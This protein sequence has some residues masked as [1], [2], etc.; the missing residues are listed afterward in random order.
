MAA[1]FV[2][3]ILAFALAGICTLPFLL[4]YRSVQLAQ[5]L[6]RHLSEAAFYSAYPAAFLSGDPFLRFWHTIPP[7]TTEQ[8]LL[9]GLAGLTLSL[10][11]CFVAR[12]DRRFWFYVAGILLITPLTFG[13]ALEPRGIAVLWHPYSLLAALPG[14]N[15]LR[16]PA[17]FFMLSVFCLS[18]AAGLAFAHL[19]E[20]VRLWRGLAVVVFAALV[21]DGAIDGM[22][23]GVPPGAFTLP[24]RDGRLLALP[25]L[26]LTAITTV[27]Y[28]SMSNG[29][30]VIN[31][32]AGYVPPSAD[33]IDWALRRRDQTVLE[34][35]RAGRPLYVIVN[36]GGEADAW[37]AFMDAQPGVTMLG[38]QA[39]GRV[40]RLPAGGILRFL[41]PR[42]RCE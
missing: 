28:A 6:T 9:P 42:R 40:Y 4:R 37:S 34:P 20:R 25:F 27:M 7:R 1:R 41:D 31:G 15:G 14:F 18:I 16:V 5:G 24:D 19:Q 23:L 33:V 8:Y 38:I 36:S 30:P 22:P 39:G 11:G 2:R 26:D 35:L 3:V 21:F 10:V 32:Y 13:P 29:M 12:R 17:R